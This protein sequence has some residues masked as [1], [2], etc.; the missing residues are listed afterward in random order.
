MNKIKI[1]DFEKEI[2]DILDIIKNCK[3]I[4]KSITHRLED[5]GFEYVEIGTGP[6]S[7]ICSRNIKILNCR[8]N[9]FYY[10]NKNLIF[11]VGIHNI[12][13]LY[14]GYA[15]EINYTENYST[16][17]IKALQDKLSNILKKYPN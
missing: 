12:K 14:R 16:N 8:L 3:L 5:N 6:N 11:V 15:K 4:D 10:S 7:Y 13:G 17:D 9:K 1:E 2:H